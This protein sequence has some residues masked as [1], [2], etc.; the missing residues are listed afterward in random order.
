MYITMSETGNSPAPNSS[1]LPSGMVFKS[2]LLNEMFSV[3]LRETGISRREILAE[4]REHR[5]RDARFAMYLALRKRAY[6]TPQIGSIMN[7]DH[8]TVVSGVKTARKYYDEKPEFRALVD[9]L[10]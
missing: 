7:R 8:T 9:A 10:V 4:I 3:V 1:S 2:D 5:V 6:S